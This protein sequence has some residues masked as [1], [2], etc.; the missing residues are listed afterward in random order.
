MLSTARSPHIVH[1]YGACLTPQICIVLEHCSRG[2]LFAVLNEPNPKTVINWTVALKYAI[3]MTKGMQCLHTWKPDPILHR[4]VKTV[5]L[6]VNKDGDLK[7][8]DLGLARFNNARSQDTMNRL[9]GTYSYLPPEIFFGQRFTEKADIFSMGVILWEI[10][11]R[12]IFGKYMLPYAEFDI[13]V[14][15]LI[16]IQVAEKHVRPT[17]PPSCPSSLSQLI[18]QTMDVNP[19]N[20]PTSTQLLEQLTAMA[21]D[22]KKKS[23]K[24]ACCSCTTAMVMLL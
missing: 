22:C 13:K 19:L 18:K 6:L 1:F 10:V 23:K 4:D 20:R 21:D 14:D 2:S 15:Y 11:Y 16:A 8:G 3:D 24:M 9:C 12:V 17:I 7:V 5:N